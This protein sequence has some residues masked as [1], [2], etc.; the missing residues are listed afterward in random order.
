MEG[1]PGSALGPPLPP[2][3]DVKALCWATSSI[4]GPSVD[5]RAELRA[6]VSGTSSAATHVTAVHAERNAMWSRN[7]ALR[8]AQGMEQAPLLRIGNH[9][10]QLPTAP[11]EYPKTL[12]M[13]IQSE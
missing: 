1:L 9:L 13:A 3:D 6:S 7:A 5:S 10:Y 11:A 2:T 8:L 12:P 4:P